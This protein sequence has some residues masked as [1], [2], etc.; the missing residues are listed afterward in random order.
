MALR[1]EP[2]AARR[3]GRG[4]RAEHYWHAAYSVQIIPVQALRAL[5]YEFESRQLSG[6]SKDFKG[7]SVGSAGVRQ[8]R[9]SPPAC[10]PLSRCRQW[11]EAALPERLIASG[12]STGPDLVEAMLNLEPHAAQLRQ[13]LRLGGAQDDHGCAAARRPAARLG[14]AGAM[15]ALGAAFPLNSSRHPPFDLPAGGCPEA[16]SR[17]CAALLGDVGEARPHAHCSGACTITCRQLQRQVST[18]TLH[19]QAVPEGEDPARS[20]AG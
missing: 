17:S 2:L 5:P 18:R 19:A 20:M 10:G 9:G 14:R 1:Q 6:A 13:D 4:G 15:A 8:P 7:T 16:R 11:A 3:H 12:R